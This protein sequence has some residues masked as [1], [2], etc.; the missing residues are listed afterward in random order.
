MKVTFTDSF[1]KSLKTLARH[2]TWW[3]KTYD[4]VRRDL[5]RFFKNI[6]LFRK[7][8][9]LYAWWDYRFT[10]DMLERSLR[11]QQ[12]GMETKGIEVSET[13]YPKVMSMKRAIR[14]LENRKTDNFIDRAEKELGQLKNMDKCIFDNFEETPEDMTHNKKVFDRATEIE[15]KEWKELWEIFKGTKNSKTYGDKYDGTDLRSWWD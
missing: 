10:L 1:F 4:F 7:E 12:H 11:I 6:Y 8:L 2:Q 14:F 3:Y 15:N 5:P 9:L 13:R